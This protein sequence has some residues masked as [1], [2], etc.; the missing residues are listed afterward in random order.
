[1]PK[2]PVLIAVAIGALGVLGACS[3]DSEQAMKA[4]NDPRVVDLDK[5]DSNAAG[6]DAAPVQAPL[7]P[8]Q[9][10]PSD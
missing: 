3:D 10:A 7:P 9:A 6:Q 5:L 2:R 1:L 8:P 4:P